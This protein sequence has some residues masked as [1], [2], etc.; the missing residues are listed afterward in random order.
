[1]DSRRKCQKRKRD[2]LFQQNNHQ[3]AI[4]PQHILHQSQLSIRFFGNIKPEDINENTFVELF[5]VVNRDGIAQHA[6]EDFDYAQQ[7]NNLEHYDY[8]LH[9]NDE[10]IKQQGTE[11]TDYSQ[12]ANDLAH[13]DY[14]LEVGADASTQQG[15]EGFDDLQQV[16]DEFTAQPYTEDFDYIHQIKPI[17][18]YDYSLQVNDEFTAQQYT[19]DF[20]YSQ[21]DINIE[22]HPA[23][24]PF[25]PAYNDNSIIK[26][27]MYLRDLSQKENLANTTAVLLKSFVDEIKDTYPKPQPAP[28]QLEVDNKP[29]DNLENYQI[30]ITLK[31]SSL[32]SI[33]DLPIFKDDFRYKAAL[34]PITHT[35]TITPQVYFKDAEEDYKKDYLYAL[36]DKLYFFIPRRDITQCKLYFCNKFL[37]D[38]N[39]PFERSD[40]VTLTIEIV[41]THTNI[42]LE[43]F[44]RTIANYVGR[45][46]LSLTTSKGKIM[47]VKDE[48]NTILNN[49]YYFNFIVKLITSL[50]LKEHISI[51]I[52]Y[53]YK[54]G[55]VLATNTYRMENS[56][57]SFT[58]SQTNTEAFLN[59]PKSIVDLAKE[60]IGF[61]NRLHHK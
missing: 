40:K 58:L 50:A 12:Q 37:E 49:K 32:V 43:E 41:D 55:D 11:I 22:Y 38:L 60:K 35:I 20:D 59:K 31:E 15:T 19:E 26:D 24:D 25:N 7:V 36:I 8:S 51:D 6:T 30:K 61:T 28:I 53:T 9:I 27:Q 46:K 16:N 1:M 34:D 17:A 14:S 13:Y 4:I 18:N 39:P 47:T 23:D 57:S 45:H 54:H 21:Q 48:T 56:Y 29:Q 2:D 44:I 42:H 5:K 52:S 3:A 33:L 10:A